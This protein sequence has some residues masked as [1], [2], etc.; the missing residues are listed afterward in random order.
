MIQDITI[1]CT[2]NNNNWTSVVQMLWKI[3]TH[4]KFFFPSSTLYRSECNLNFGFKE[5]V[6]AH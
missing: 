5:E 3:P 1:I 2:T 6:N 4:L